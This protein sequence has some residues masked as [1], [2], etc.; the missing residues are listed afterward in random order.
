MPPEME[1]CMKKMGRKFGS[2]EADG[3]PEAQAVAQ[4]V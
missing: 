3:H 4:A 2:K 1:V